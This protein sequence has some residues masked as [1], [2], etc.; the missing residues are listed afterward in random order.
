MTYD[1]FFYQKYWEV[2]GADMTELA[3]NILNHNGNPTV[4]N[5]TFILLIPKCKKPSLPN[6]FR[7]IS[8]CTVLQKIVTEVITNRLK[9][10]LPNLVD[11]NQGAFVQD[12][13]IIDDGLI[14]FEIF[15]FLKNKKRER[16]GF[17]A[18]K[19]DMAK[20]YDRI[21]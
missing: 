12:R 8:L 20:A 13:Q 15:S 2:V 19:V 17:M 1:A 16:K 10:I 21:E 5:R 14:A 4:I 7:P 9:P 18:L 3:L 6:E 11:E